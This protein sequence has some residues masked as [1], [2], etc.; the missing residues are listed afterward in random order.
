MLHQTNIEI[1]VIILDLNN[2]GDPVS[3]HTPVRLEAPD[4]ANWGFHIHGWKGA[5]VE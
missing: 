2:Y 1:G 5:S 4:V 3:L